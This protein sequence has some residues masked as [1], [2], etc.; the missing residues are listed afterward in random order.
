VSPNGVLGDPSG[1]SAVEGAHL[2]AEMT[3][4]LRACLTRWHPDAT[5]RLT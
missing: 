1:A 2:L 3:A 5:G 4:A